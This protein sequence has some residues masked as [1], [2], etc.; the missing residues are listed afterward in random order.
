MSR[1]TSVVIPV[2]AAFVFVAF[3]PVVAAA[4]PAGAPDLASIAQQGISLDGAVVMAMGAAIGIG[5]LAL[6][7]MLGSEMISLVRNPI[8]RSGRRPVRR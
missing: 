8:V 5:V 7:L 2:A 6:V 3:A 4:D 1:I